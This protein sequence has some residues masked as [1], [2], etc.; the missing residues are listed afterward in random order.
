M[1]VKVRARIRR[2]C[3]LSLVKA[4]SIGVEVGAVGRQEQE[5]ASCPAHR[6]F[7]LGILVGGEIVQD[8]EDQKSIRG[9]F[10]RRMTVPGESSGTSTFS[11]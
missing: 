9:S 5:P 7:R 10:S 3:A 2:R 1:S 8:E 6:L 4:I 11:T